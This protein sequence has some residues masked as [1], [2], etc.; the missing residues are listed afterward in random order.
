MTKEIKGNIWKFGKKRK[1]L[2]FWKEKKFFLK[3]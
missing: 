2:K 1:Y 3:V